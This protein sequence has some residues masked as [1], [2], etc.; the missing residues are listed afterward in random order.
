MDKWKTG[1]LKNLGNWPAKGCSLENV[2]YPGSTVAWNSNVVKLSYCEKNWSTFGPISVRQTF[3]C[4]S[5]K[6]MLNFAVSCQ[7]LIDQ[8]V[9]LSAEISTFHKNWE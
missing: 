7:I 2:H 5:S 3:K 4:F 1:Y 8:Q 6:D 9:A